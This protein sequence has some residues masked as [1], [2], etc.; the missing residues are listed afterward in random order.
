MTGR[1]SRHQV[2]RGPT[3]E[4][5]LDAQANR[6]ARPGSVRRPRHL[7]RRPA[8]G[9][10]KLPAIFGSHMVLQQKQKDRVWGSA[11]PG[12]EVTVTIADQTKTTKADDDGKWSVT[13]DPLPAGGPHTLTVEGK[14][15]V[16]FDDVLVGEVWLC[17]G[18]SNMQWPSTR[19]T[20]ATSR[21]WRPNYPEDPPDLGAAGRHAG[22]AGRLQGQVGGLHARDRRAVLGRRLLLRPAAAPDARRADR[23]DRR[24]LGRLGLRGLGPPRPARDRRE[25]QAADRPL[26]EDR[27]E[28]A[29]GRPYEKPDRGQRPPRRPRPR[30]SR[31]ATGRRTPTH[32]LRG[33]ARP[34]NIY[35]GVL[36]PTI[37]Y[38]IAGRSG[39]RA[40]R[41]P[42][43]PTSIAT[44]SR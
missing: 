17:S 13:L 10:V 6:P 2:T 22:A 35:N 41:T 31:P 28:R 12:E 8:R 33:N 14:N 38:G 11:D 23:P 26:G 1:D 20:T 3:R 16:T 15:T 39:T 27:E 24:L 30:A 18:Q 32:Q 19:P 7:G 21:A 34:G 40:S 43:A 29:A 37:G 5:R 36:K 44:S 4:K 42:A 25:V 9:D